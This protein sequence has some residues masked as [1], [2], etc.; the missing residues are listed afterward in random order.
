[1]A[2][3]LNMDKPIYFDVWHYTFNDVFE[4]KLISSSKGN[5]QYEPVNLYSPALFRGDS[6]KLKSRPN[7]LSK[8]FEKSDLIQRR[9]FWYLKLDTFDSFL[10]RRDSIV[11]KPAKHYPTTKTYSKLKTRL[12]YTFEVIAFEKSIFVEHYNKLK[13]EHYHSADYKIDSLKNSNVGLPESMVKL[14]ILKVDQEIVALALIID[15]GKAVS[16]QVPVAKRTKYGFGLVLCTE[17]IHY[18][19]E[20]NYYSFDAGVSNLYGIYKQKIYLDSFEIKKPII[21]EVK[22]F[23]KRML[24]NASKQ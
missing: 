5:L 19:S 13:P 18:Y 14:A 15:D 10:K 12:E 22:L 20:K 16:L 21:K 6:K 3:D 23:I 2:S 4:K 1:M 7:V 8:D 9:V 17:L 11:T 24:K